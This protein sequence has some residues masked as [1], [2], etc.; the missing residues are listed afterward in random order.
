MLSKEELVKN[1][2][3]KILASRGVDKN[4]ALLLIKDGCKL[5]VFEIVESVL[6]ALLDCLPKDAFISP[7]NPSLDMGYYSYYKQLLAMREIDQPPTV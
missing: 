4:A 2:G 5:E 6:H 7:I 1:A 3:L